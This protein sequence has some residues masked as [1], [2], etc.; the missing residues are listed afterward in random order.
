MRPELSTVATPGALLDQT[1]ATLGIGCESA[2]PTICHALAVAI[3]SLP[4]IRIFR[5]VTLTWTDAS[6]SVG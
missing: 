2:G 4:R 5:G 1:N 3:V 6:R